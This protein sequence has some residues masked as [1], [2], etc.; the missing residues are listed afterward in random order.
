MIYRELFPRIK[1]LGTAKMLIGF[2]RKNK[3][4]II[5][6]FLVLFFLTINIFT[7]KNYG[8]T[9]D[10][11]FSVMRGK[12]TIEYISKVFETGDFSFEIWN[13]QIESHPPFFATI[14][15]LFSIF[16]RKYLGL[17]YIDSCHLLIVI[18]YSI[19]LFFL[20][21]LARSMLGDK[22]GLYALVFT[23]L[24][25]RLIAHSHYNQ[26]DIPVM[27]LMIISLY[28]LYSSFKSKKRYLPILAGLF[29]GMSIASKITGVFIVP[30][31]FS[32]LIFYWIFKKRP[33]S[34][35][36]LTKLA[37]FLLFAGISI[38]ILWPYMWGDPLFLVKS[39]SHFSG[40]F[41]YTKTIYFGTTYLASE[42]PWHYVLFSVFVMTPIIVLVLSLVGFYKLLR[43]NL[44]EFFILFFWF[45]IPI[46]VFIGFVDLRYSMNRHLFFIVPSLTIAA[47]VGLDRFLSKIRENSKKTALI[48]L[49]II[50]VFLLRE[51]VIIHP[52][53]QT[54]VNGLVRLLVPDNLE[55]E[56]LLAHWGSVYRKGNEWINE[57]AEP[58]SRICFSGPQHVTWNLPKREDLTFGCDEKSDY[59]LMASCY[60]SEYDYPIVHKIS[61]YGK[62]DI[63]YIKSN[64]D[65]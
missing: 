39:L 16:G 55:K 47:G 17:G 48:V 42:V 53:E 60:G 50:I 62:T 19:G 24:Y 31:I 33:P 46:V 21:L 44:L 40:E 51:V 61:I 59:F 26:K 27:V 35:R 63:F 29:A 64:K 3:H 43:R 5:A 30:I 37:V 6:L 58:G 25:P 54:H 28:F 45:F 4:L 15:H 57:N 38:F 11:A 41:T 12:R 18:T 52:F 34:K 36:I 56:F 8:E 2:L 7:L 49:F 32:A 10:E 20:F 65:N 13:K 22:I 9:I 1:S 14:N 23:M